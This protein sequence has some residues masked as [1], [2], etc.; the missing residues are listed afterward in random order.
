MV[1]GLPGDGP[2]DDEPAGAQ[3]T[4]EVVRLVDV[5][6]V[7]LAGELDVLSVGRLREVLDQ[8]L[9]AGGP[10]VVDLRGLAFIDSAGLGAL[11]RAHKKARVLRGQLTC[12]YLPDSQP[13]MLFRI[14]GMHR[15]LRVSASLDG[16]LDASHPLQPGAGG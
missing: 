2:H 8:L 5:P 11:V 3:L 14:T 6:V 9:L 16:A 15:V 10:V 7:R 12:L 13:S 4:I 1:E